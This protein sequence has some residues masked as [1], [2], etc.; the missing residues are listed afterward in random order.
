MKKA[1]L[2][3]A[4]ALTPGG[5]TSGTLTESRHGYGSK[6]DSGAGSEAGVGIAGAL[7]IT[8]T[9]TDTRASLAAGSTVNLA[10]GTDGDTENGGDSDVDTEVAEGGAE[11]I[12]ANED[13]RTVYL[14]QEFRL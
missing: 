14:G 10:D 12:L 9:S 4:I 8:T 11:E 2:G 1:Q 3:E 13:V 6:A 5:G 7:A